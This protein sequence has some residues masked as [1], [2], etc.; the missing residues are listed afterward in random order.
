MKQATFDRLRDTSA[1]LETATES[2]P[3]RLGAYDVVG[4]IAEG[5]MGRVYDA[6]HRD[7]RSR[8]ALK[9][10]THLSA[11][12]ILRFKNEFR[13]VADLC[14]PNLVPLYELCCHEG[15]W[16]I[17]M[18]RV[19]GVS[20]LEWIRPPVIADLESTLLDSRVVERAPSGSG[21]RLATWRD[22]ALDARG[23]PSAPP[24][25]DRL[26]DALGGLVRGVSA[27]HAAGLLHLDLKP[28]NVLVDD[29]GHVIILDFGLARLLEA[30][31]Q[32]PGAPAPVSGTPLWMPPEQFESGTLDAAAD[33]YAVG[34]MLQTALTGVYPFATD[35]VAA[36]WKDKRRGEVPAARRLVREV[37]EELSRLAIAL[38]NPDPTRRPRGPEILARLAGAPEGIKQAASARGDLVGRTVE[39]GQLREALRDARAQ[40]P[41]I[42]HV[43][44]PSGVGKSA[45]LRAFVDE[46]SRDEGAVVLR[47]RCYERET[48]PYKAFDGVMDELAVLLERMPQEALLQRLPARIV[49]LA[50]VFP[51]LTKVW[52]VARKVR[53]AV[54]LSS[55]LS[56]VELRER[57][58]EGLRRLLPL[59]SRQAL[60]VLQIDDLQWADAD[61]AEL[62]SALLT[63]PCPPQLALAVTFRPLEAAQNR[64]LAPYFEQVRALA[65]DGS[66]R[67]VD[68]RLE[69]LPDEDA[70]TLAAGTLERLG[71]SP[72]GLDA[73]IASESRGVPFFVEELARFAAQ[74]IEEHGEGRP[75]EVSLA[76]VLSRR[77]AALDPR[78][79]AL[80]EVL[81]VSSSPIPLSAWFSVAATGEHGLRA[82]WSL[83]GQRFVR[84]HGAGA[85]DLIEMDHD[86]MREAVSS[87]VDPAR[88]VR[89]HRDLGRE[90]A[91]RGPASPWR[92]DALRHLSAARPIL[93]ETEREEAASLA[94]EA[95]RAA[96]GS[97]AFRLSF[98]CFRAGI[99]LLGESP[100]DARYELALALHTGAAD[101]AYLCAEWD[102][103]DAHVEAVIAHSRAHLDRLGAWEASIDGA[104][105]RTQNDRAVDTAL[106]ALSLLGMD[107]PRHPTPE[108]VGAFAGRAIAA[109]S[110]VTP[111]QLLELPSL[112]SPRTHAVLRLQSRIASATFFARPA[113]FPVLA[114]NA[115]C[116]TLAEGVSNASPFALSVFAVVLNSIGQ[117]S[118]AHTWGRAA[119]ALLERSTDRAMDARTRHVVH[120]LVCVF[121]VPLDGTLEDLRAVVDLGQELGDTE[122]AAYAA[123]AYVHNALYA[124][125]P[126][127]PLLAEAEDFS[128]FM[129]RSDQNNA[130]HVHALFE[131]TLRALAG[132]TNDPSRLDGDGF[133]EES[134]LAA[135]RASGSRSGQFLLQLL[136]GILRFHF[137]DPAEASALLESARPFIDG[138]AST[139]HVPIF[140]QYA[141][142]AA[143]ASA[144]EEGE[145]EHRAAAEASPREREAFAEA[146]L[147]ELETFAEAGPENFAHR[148][149]LVRAER[150]RARGDD[151]TARTHY[152]DAARGAAR[153]RFWSD[154]GLAHERLAELDRAVGD[155]RAAERAA[156]SA[157]EAYA[158]WGALAKLSRVR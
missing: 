70:R 116:L 53:G 88:E 98:D 128:A 133:D 63:P 60:V 146:S 22:P 12:R 145:P 66:L 117:F 109:I 40:G 156:G 78:E 69:P 134:A 123:H 55:T 13:Y 99:A 147:R 30:P 130:L 107:L 106:D 24:S 132:R 155:R 84:A 150:A 83:R 112:E 89:I 36:I 158:R 131:R 62:L 102:A 38:L 47:G 37:P 103:L 8:V 94:L 76:T 104:I 45:L 61:S 119:L 9:T 44:G 51:T 108:Q 58:A 75:V 149:A 110:A 121:T 35:S 18:E 86:R 33:W 148:V 16:F 81:S 87:S 67:H 5:G 74:Q 125:R 31:G 120:D 52:T 10:L 82:L 54:A 96:R 57:A 11:D 23:E 151:G 32:E 25:I 7:H 15:L 29:Q 41:I 95:G 138:V 73:R 153:G 77:L 50:R 21:V 28:S 129:T 42:A 27:L 43:S 126:I 90:L 142:M 65:G 140:H 135:A 26:R 17:T 100:W 139:W 113:L 115:L 64:A 101:T 141:A 71:L 49:D 111:E 6:V 157:R 114:C 79:R 72:H 80:V 122:Y 124:S 19:R 14:H 93:S 59:L 85:D 4:T 118:A 127:G 136:R 105:A 97:G 154:A 144:K 48:V 92:Y 39:R 137:S 2:E 20:W 3:V 56:I 152:Q 34:L 1:A 68:V 143:W 91:A 46:A